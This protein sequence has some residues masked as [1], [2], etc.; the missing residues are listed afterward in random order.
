MTEKDKEIQDLR[1]EVELMGK[2]NAELRTMH[3]CDM[4]EIVRLRREIERLTD[5]AKRSD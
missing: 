5:E 1:R 3:Y 4:A 2:E